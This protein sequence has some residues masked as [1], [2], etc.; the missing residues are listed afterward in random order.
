MTVVAFR[1]AAPPPQR[2][3]AIYCVQ[4]YWRDRKGLA[5]G[6][7]EQF[8]A[9]EPAMRAA[10]AGSVRAAGVAVYVYRGY[11]GTDTWD[12]PVRVARFGATPC[13]KP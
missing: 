10:K 3:V 1:A 5:K 13:E 12:E 11:V 7:F 8:A 9:L 6:K 2:K 4:A